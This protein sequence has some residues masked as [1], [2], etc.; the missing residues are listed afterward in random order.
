MMRLNYSS[1]MKR[2]T[3]IMC[4]AKIINTALII[5]GSFFT[6]SAMSVN[7]TASHLTL[8]CSGRGRVDVIF[9]VYGHR[10]EMWQGNFEIGSGHRVSNGVDIVRFVNGDILFHDMKLDRYAF[11]Y[12]KSDKSL[13]PCVVVAE[14]K[15]APV[16]LWTVR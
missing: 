7:Y 12:N 15:T 10:Q 5:A 3:L 1:L 8:N 4:K 14:K 9:H 13:N 2:I 11:H 6:A 16:N